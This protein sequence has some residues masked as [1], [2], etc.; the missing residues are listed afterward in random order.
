MVTSATMGEIPAGQTNSQ[1]PLLYPGEVL[2]HI[3]GFPTIYHY[4]P[5]TVDGSNNNAPK[6][7]IVCV[8]GGLH[9]AR[10]FYGGHEGARREDFIAYWLNQQGFNVLS[11]S[12]PLETEDG[13]MPLTG[14][15]FRITDWGLQA[16][17]TTRQIM[18]R[19]GYRDRTLIL[20]SWSM[21]GRMVVR[22]NIAAKALGLDVALFVSFA[23]TPGLSS[24]RPPPAGMTCSPAGYFHVR[25]HL[26]VFH[27]HLE[28]MVGLND[29]DG[30]TG[31]TVIP[32]DVYLREYCGGSPINLI[33][34]QLRYEPAE[35]RFVRDDRTHEED[36]RVLD[37]ANLPLI[38]AI[39]PTSIMDASHALADK[40]GWGFLLTYK[41]EAMI[42]TQGLQNVRGTP[43]WQRLLDLVHSASGRLFVATPGNHLFF[44]GEHNARVAVEK[45][46]ALFKEAGTFERELLQLI[47]V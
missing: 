21:A 17:T 38:A 10:V 45:V 35:G 37:V 24:I 40:A 14:T 9:L 42:G 46:E 36:T 43:K 29:H 33:G 30:N 4:S 28:E 19:K 32:R 15:H 31:H 1:N 23:A 27:E 25:T 7:L 26:D 11:L 3:A 34:L 41:L 20:I 5:A 16:A 6:P 47:A 8:T 22:F 39:Y 44:I 12:Y 18:D 2:D 13:I